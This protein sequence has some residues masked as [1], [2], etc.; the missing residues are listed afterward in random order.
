MQKAKQDFFKD[1]S[2]FYASFPIVEQAKKNKWNFKLDS[3]YSVG[4][5]DFIFEDHKEEKGFFHVVQLKDQHCNVFYDKLKF[6]YIEL[7][8]IAK[9][10]PEERKGYQSS[11]KYYWDLNNV[12][13]FSRREGVKEGL[14]EGIERGLAKGRI[15]TQLKIAKALKESGIA[16]AIIAQTTGLSEEQIKQL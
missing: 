16:T 8:K 12:V 13:D 10:T 1:R 5:L 4:I 7:R 15:Q 6:I 11:L 3:V 14:I 2:V 9:F